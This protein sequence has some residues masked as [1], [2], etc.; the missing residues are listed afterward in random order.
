MAT[1]Y[2]NK[3]L[4]NKSPLT[5]YQP[6]NPHVAIKEGS[7]SRSQQKRSEPILPALTSL[8]YSACAGI[9]Q[10]NRENP[11]MIR[12]IW[13]EPLSGYPESPG[14]AYD[15]VRTGL[16]YNNQK[17]SFGIDD[18]ALRSISLWSLFDES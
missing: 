8:L 4:N 14:L 11:F 5:I 12:Y 6:P 10:C 1:L 3:L 7:R 16:M 2:T 13:L 9:F 17:L 18:F 15:V